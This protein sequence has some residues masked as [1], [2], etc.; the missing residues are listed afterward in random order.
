MAP[1]PLRA[2]D[3][4]GSRPAQQIPPENQPG[5]ALPQHERTVGKLVERNVASELGARVRSDALGMQLRVDG[6]GSNLA[7]VELAPDRD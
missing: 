6:I 4:A 2:L 1:R 5:C 7:G 3:V